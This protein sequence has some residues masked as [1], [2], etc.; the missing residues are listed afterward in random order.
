MPSAWRLSIIEPS[1]EYFRHHMNPRD[2]TPAAAPCR[3]Q[4]S[5]GFVLADHFTLSSFAVFADLV[6]LAADEGDLSRQVKISWTVMGSQAAPT[7]A[8][9][10][11]MVERTSEFVD[12]RRF[13]YVV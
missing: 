13:D 10:G 3:S 9:C 2:L 12:P 5:L 8:S 4:L 1:L 7:Q 6:R 11:V